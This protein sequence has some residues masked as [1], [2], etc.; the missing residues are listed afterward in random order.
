MAVV[1]DVSYRDARG[2]VGKLAAGL[3]A[4]QLLTPV[5]ATPEWTVYEL[6]SHLVGAAADAASDRLD[7]AP[8]AQWTTRHVGE[9]RRR[10]VDE[11]V[12]EWERVAPAVELD[13]AGQHFSG[14]GPAPDLICHAADLRE[15]LC[16]PRVDREHWQQPFLEGMML[17]LGQRLQH[18]ATVL[19]RDELGWQWRCGSREPT[20][21]LFA[22]GYELLRAMFSRRSRRQITAWNWTPAPTEQVVDSFGFF[23]P[24]DDDQ[25]V[26]VG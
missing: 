14:P 25:P 20:T 6:L 10:S 13:L 5:P 9:R 15:A 26:P 11:L 21:L 16:L 23:G 4:E 2:C 19:V 22:D 3:S 7:G 12:D 1:L 17:L 18:A 8:G 24:R